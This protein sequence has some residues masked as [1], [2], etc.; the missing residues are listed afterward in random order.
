[1]APN[2]P[3]PIGRPTT[4]WRSRTSVR[5]VPAECF[6]FSLI[7]KLQTRWKFCH[8]FFIYLVPKSKC[9]L[10]PA[11]IVG[12][13]R[14]PLAGCFSCSICWLRETSSLT[15]NQRVTFLS[16]GTNTLLENQYCGSSG[17]EGMDPIEFA[18]SRLRWITQ[19]QIRPLVFTENSN[20]KS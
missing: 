7:L 3:A 1:M 5:T 2:P 20:Q 8:F 11:W 6:H 18:R 10:L 16:S 14:H 12:A 4:H 13:R 17:Y 15:N 9:A 19:I